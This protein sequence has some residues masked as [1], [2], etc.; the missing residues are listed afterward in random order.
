MSNPFFPQFRASFIRASDLLR[1]MVSSEDASDM[2]SSEDAGGASSLE[3]AGRLPTSLVSSSSTPAPASRTIV[4]QVASSHTAGLGGAG[5]SA[6]D[7]ASLSD[8]VEHSSADATVLGPGPCD[9]V[10]SVQVAIHE[11]NSIDWDSLS[12]SDFIHGSDSEVQAAI[13]ELNSI[14]W[15]SLSEGEFFQG[16]VVE[17]RDPGRG[18]AIDA[19]SRARVER[20]A[21]S[22]SRNDH[23]SNNVGGGEILGKVYGVPLRRIIALFLES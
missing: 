21:A 20:L 1:D 19:K 16:T 13:R 23:H 9:Q 22:S 4:G 7:Q 15:D 17:H 10:D 12:D 8:A 5:V 14:E 18:A 2:V 6:L 11:L 3:D